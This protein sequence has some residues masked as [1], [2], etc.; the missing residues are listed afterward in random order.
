[1]QAFCIERLVE[2]RDGSHLRIELPSLEFRLKK[3]NHGETEAQT[4]ILLEQISQITFSE[5]PAL[6]RVE[7]IKI[8]LQALRDEDFATREAAAL[9]LTK[10]GSGFRELLQ[11]NLDRAFDPEI[12]WRLR[13]VLEH[14]PINARD[15]FDHVRLKNKH[16]RGELEPWHMIVNYRGT[17]LTLN[18]STVSSIRIAP[19]THK[20]ARHVQAVNNPDSDLIPLACRKIDFEFNP[21]GKILRAGENIQQAFINWGLTL[22][23]SVETSFV[24]VNRYDIDGAGGGKAAATHDPLYEGSITIRFCVP[25]YPS[26][27]SG[28]SFIGCWLGIVKPG[29]TSMVAYD[30]YGS[31]IGRAVTGEGESQFLGVK[32]NVP[33]A[34]VE[35]VP[36]PVI[37]SN[38]AFDDLIY[39]SPTPL[40][41]ALHP[42]HFSI[43]LHDGNRF[44]C[45]AIIPQKHPKTGEISIL[46]RPGAAFT[47]EIPI[48]LKEISILA[49]PSGKRQ[50]PE[51]GKRNIWAL[52]ND[53]S[54]LSLLTPENKALI[55]LL[56]EIPAENLQICSL[57]TAPR[58]L[59]DP[60]DNLAIP[61]SGAAIIIR[62]DPLYLTSF[63][64]G[65]DKF[66]GIRPDGS[67]INY[68]Y[69]R[70]PN[71]W[72]EKPSGL[73]APIGRIELTD[74]QAINFGKECLFSSCT[75]QENGIIIKV[76]TTGN[77]APQE[78][79]SINLGFRKVRAVQFY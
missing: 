44:N 43:S 26:R 73:P 47:R 79:Q 72:I 13:R 64:L 56:G 60:P 32:S 25:G 62:N 31:E 50:P 5:I 61:R 38:F 41:D 18:R 9:T 66:S 10:F 77:S 17:N 55:T 54:Q 27:R 45:R 42:S 68:S 57:W 37:D 39:D 20:Q 21:A 19:A 59:Q 69:N 14:L 6:N 23:S 33:I 40:M 52:L 71:I 35:I 36:N 15:E 46:A 65:G 30:A 7:R 24:S 78:S 76:K 1:M 34:R 8:A 2:F 63:T 49:P 22:S 12:R 11:G 58:K 74:G 28:V 48:P 51:P 53:G 75:I 4:K 16:L 3:G 67:T 29:G 70:L